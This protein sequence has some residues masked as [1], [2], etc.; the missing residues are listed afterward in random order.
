MA[1]KVYL[2][3][4]LT[5]SGAFKGKREVYLALRRGEVTVE[6]VVVTNRLYQLKPGKRE[7][8]WRGVRL[9]SRG[10]IYIL[11]NKPAGF[12]CSRLTAADVRL[13]KKS[14]FDLIGSEIDVKTRNSLFSVGRLD[15]D[16]SGLLLLTND[17]KLCS[18]ITSPKNNVEKT[19]AVKVERPVSVEEACRLEDGVVIDLEDDGEVVKYKTRRCRLAFTSPGHRKLLLTVVEGR[20]REVRRMFESLGNRVVGLERVSVGSLRLRDLRIRKGGYVVSDRTFIEGKVFNV[21][22]A[23]DDGR[24]D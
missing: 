4:F 24:M 20:K 19:Y 17:G 11:M 22:Q 18:R 7:V 12:L 6:G 13:G 3:Q 5:G 21:E 23:A 2:H 1:L 10:N 14:V 9:A 8:C 16:T 15:E